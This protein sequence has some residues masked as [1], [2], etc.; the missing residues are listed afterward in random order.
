MA[1]L[2]IC[3]GS[4]HAAEPNGD[5]T[6]AVLPSSATHQSS[7]LSANA[8]P[9]P[10]WISI[11]GGVADLEG[12]I[13]Y[14]ATPSDG[15][16]ALN[17]ATG[18]VLW[19]T[20]EAKYP[21]ALYEG[22]LLAQTQRGNSKVNT[23]GIVLF[24]ADSNHVAKQIEPIVFPDWVAVDGGIGLS[25]ASSVALENDDL[26]L[27]WQAQREFVGGTPRTPEAVAAAKKA[28]SGVAHVDLASGKSTVD[29]DDAFKP[30]KLPK[31]K[32]YYD[33]A[34]K[35]LS[36]SDSSE[37]LPGG[38]QIVHRM[39]EV[40]SGRTGR[41]LWHREIAGDIILPANLPAN[42]PPNPPTTANKSASGP[43]TPRR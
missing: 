39:L 28:Q 23:L 34:D 3:C 15:I 36:T 11:P 30:L 26:I 20:K 13:A 25:F 17:L 1:I 9:T 5:S 6:P 4:L 18:Q 8:K 27:S 37:N 31:A 29:I 43:G 33:V 21:I 7:E 16:E 2:S 42:L 22:Q 24:E 41:P 10:S 12:K 38:I 35:R 32:P 19:E 14:V 40:R